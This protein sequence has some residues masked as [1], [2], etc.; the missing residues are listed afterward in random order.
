MTRARLLIFAAAVLIWVA[1]FNGWIAAA[2]LFVG[3]AVIMIK[4]RRYWFH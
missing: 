3:I 2:L 1:V 4:D